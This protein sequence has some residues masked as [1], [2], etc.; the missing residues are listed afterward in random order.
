MKLKLP[1]PPTCPFCGSFIQKPEVIPLP[2][3]EHEGGV[4]Q[5]GAVYTLSSTGYDRGSAFISALLLALSGDWDLAWDLIPDEDYKEIWIEGYDPEN[6]LVYPEG[7]DTG[8]K[9]RSALVFIKLADD[10]QELK[11]EN[12]SKI[13]KRDEALLDT[14][15]KKR[16]PRQELEN[17]VCERNFSDLVNY[18]LAEPKNLNELQK[19]LYHPEEKIRLLSAY[20]LG[21]AAGL[22]NKREPQRVLDL[23]KRL[24]YAGAD[25]ASSAW[26]ALP[27]CGEVIRNTGDQYSAYVK[28]IL[29][30]LAFKENIPHALIALARISEVNPKS[31]KDKP[32][33]RLISVFREKVPLWQAYIIQIFSNLKAR[34]LLSER[35]FLCRDEVRIFDFEMADY[36]TVNL[37][38]LWSDYE[39]LFRD[40]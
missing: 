24:L 27:A 8:R 21:L 11:K 38:E 29:A 39:K 40:L 32:Y 30:F 14:T 36:K 33:L 3:V 22:L 7:V 19:L 10:V 26:G 1:Y 13:L 23:I 5:C 12:L 34:E 16:L 20:G 15:F 17:L 31:I 35:E 18:L 9:I 4:C 28:N 2:Y 6:H 25:S 37:E